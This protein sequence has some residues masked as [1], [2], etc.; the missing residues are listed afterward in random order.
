[1][2]EQLKHYF[3]TFHNVSMHH[4]NIKAGHLHLFLS[5]SYEK[6]TLHIINVKLYRYYIHIMSH[7]KSEKK[8][9]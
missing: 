3:T 9:Q 1:M 2:S 5:A 6:K 4:S 7:G 8:N